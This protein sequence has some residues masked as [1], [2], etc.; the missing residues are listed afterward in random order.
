MAV[1]SG[2][3]AHNDMEK[4]KELEEKEEARR[5]DR[6]ESANR[7]IANYEKEKR[8]EQIKLEKES[9]QRQDTQKIS[10]GPELVKKLE[11]L[12]QDRIKYKDTIE[13]NKELRALY[14]NNRI[15]IYHQPAST[16]YEKYLANIDYTDG[17]YAFFQEHYKTKLDNE[18]KLQYEKDS[19]KIKMNHF[20]VIFIII[21]I[22]VLIVLL[23]ENISNVWL[24]L[25]LP[26][27]IIGYISYNI[28]KRIL[29]KKYTEKQNKKKQIFQNI[30]NIYND[31]IKNN[32]IGNEENKIRNI[33]NDSGGWYLKTKKNIGT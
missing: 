7:W 22:I 10:L 11:K 13:T 1:M 28:F 14:P 6:L 24:I 5:N 17:S 23:S 20:L 3:K 21:V 18:Y 26:I 15:Y 4:Q 12:S 30:T 32:F 16:I 9:V 19:N 29:E 27:I 2:M 8:E 33:I 31:I 25:F